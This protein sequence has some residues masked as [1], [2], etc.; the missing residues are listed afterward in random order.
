LVEPATI[1]DFMSIVK[2]TTTLQVILLAGLLPAS[3]YSQTALTW[4]QV[5]DKFVA[6]NPAFKACGSRKFG[7]G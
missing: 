7:S 4:K 5:K 1:E 6:A 3:I 2:S